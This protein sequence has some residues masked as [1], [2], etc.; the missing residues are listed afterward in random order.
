M[1]SRLPIESSDED[2][3]ATQTNLLDA[4]EPLKIKSLSE[5]PSKPLSHK[6]C[7][8]AANYWLSNRCTVTFPEFFCWNDEL[9]D[10]IGFKRSQTYLIECKVSRGDFLSDK[11]KLFRLHPERGM[12][13]F[14]YYCCPKYLIK[15]TELP[16]GW[17]LIYI[18]PSGHVRRV[19]ESSRHEK[20]LQA[21]HHLLFYYAKRAVEA[22]VHRVIL[23]QRT[24][25]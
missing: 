21:E 3:I 25:I 17:G 1:K 6:E 16:D 10:V 20:S 8:A 4:S 7:V 2:L 11:K 19:K 24:G 12:G 13:D 14:R 22:G 5:T 23:D 18:Y 15:P 9:A